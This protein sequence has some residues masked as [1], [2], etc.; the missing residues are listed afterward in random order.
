MLLNEGLRQCQSET[1][2]PFTSGY[3]RKKN[4]L[5]NVFR[6]ARTVVDHMQFKCQL[7]PLLGDHHLARDPGT[8]LNPTPSMQG[9]RRI[10]HQI[11]QHC[12]S[13]SRSPV[14]E[15]MLTS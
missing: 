4:S 2:S 15:G 11:E 13:C 9:L 8:Q 10:T 14:S 5:T 12:T 3:Q 1:R 6:D 7:P